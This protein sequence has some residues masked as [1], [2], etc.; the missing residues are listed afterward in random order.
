MLNEEA[1]SASTAHL[2]LRAVA[3]DEPA[4]AEDAPRYSEAAGIEHHPQ[5]SDFLPRRYRTIGLLA[6]LGA[7]ATASI[8]ALHRFAA[9]LAGKYGFETT[10]AFDLTR[11][12]NLAAWLSSVL[13]IL[14]AVTCILI[15][16]LRRHRIDDF[17]GRYR[18]WMAAA[19]AC[20]LLS[21][22]SVAPVHQMLAAVAAYHV[23]WTALR[24]HAAWWLLFGGLPLGWVA[25]HAWLDARES[26]LAAAALIAAMVAYCTALT[27]YLGFLPHG[28]PET[29][30]MVTCGAA[31]WGH[32][33]LLVGV[34][35]YGRFVVL[36]AQGLIP[37]RR[38][39]RAG[40][41]RRKDVK[42][43]EVRHVASR[44]TGAGRP[45][46]AAVALKATEWVDG[47]EPEIE[48]LRRRRYR[49]S[50]PQTKQS[51][52]QTAAKPKTS[53]LA[54]LVKEFTPTFAR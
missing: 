20:L 54:R 8:E 7:V 48:R 51:R 46:P 17:K 32:W 26:R 4:D 41:Q 42:G 25:V 45:D 43:R 16:S 23:G 29:A 49:L 1:L 10:A 36:D 39:E 21:V 27:S 34:V 50:R 38:R 15:Y 6:L 28:S 22:V 31:L 44:S 2:A 11:G 24:G 53:G 13:L 9:P 14:S 47:S 19:A 3:P 35:S 33:M 5:V 30:V 18:V 52:P 40:S 37:L 12:G